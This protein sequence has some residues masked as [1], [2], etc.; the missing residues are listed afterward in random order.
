MTEPGQIP[1]HLAIIMDG[2]GRWAQ[3]RFRPRVWGH[4]AGVKATRKT[5]EA[6]L[7]RKIPA[8][9]LFAF[10]SENWK[11]P[12]EEVNKLMQL[13]MDALQKE[14]PS[15][16][17]AGVC[18]RFI[19]D[20]S[21]FDQSLQAMMKQSE[22]ATAK[23]QAM[24][25]NIAVNYGGRWDILQAIQSIQSNPDLIGQINE[26]QISKNLCLSDFP[27]PDLIIRTSGEQRISNFFL[28]Q[29]A[30][31]ELYF[32]DTLWPDFDEASLDCALSAYQKR[33]RRYGRVDKKGEC[34]LNA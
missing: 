13:F 7:K 2:N 29:A 1:Q 26:D 24:Y 31:S 8:L 30:Y 3:K 18:M 19:G 6:C 5:V 27:D 28:W 14:T 33:H 22:L 11:R 16:S 10:S 15:L 12:Q 9:T 34:D 21:L 32:T 23:N 25:L 17:E 20:L 4:Q